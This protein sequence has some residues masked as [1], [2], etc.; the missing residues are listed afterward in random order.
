MNEITLFFALG[1]ILFFTSCIL[2]FVNMRASII[3]V[4]FPVGF[5]PWGSYEFCWLLISLTTKINLMG[6]E[7]MATC[8]F[9]ML[10]NLQGLGPSPPTIE[11]DN[12]KV[13]S[14]VINP[15]FPPT[16]FK[17][18]VS[19]I[20]PIYHIWNLQTN[21]AT[22]IKHTKGPANNEV[23]YPLGDQVVKPLDLTR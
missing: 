8:V 13:D 12:M 21:Q 10:H 3:R 2:N 23:G 15:T 17:V 4:K 14:R 11:A 18:V 7:N 5:C 20:N 22:T 19:V 1:H 6:P 16:T 9:N